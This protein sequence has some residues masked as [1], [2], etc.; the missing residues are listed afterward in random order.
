MT[1]SGMY[2]RPFESL[3]LL[4]YIII[5]IDSSIGPNARQVTAELSSSIAS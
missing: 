2:R 1:T 4:S 3:Y 5:N